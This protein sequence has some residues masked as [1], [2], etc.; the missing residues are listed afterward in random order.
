MCTASR[1]GAPTSGLQQQAAAQRLRNRELLWKA[2]SKIRKMG[3]N[4]EGVEKSVCVGGGGGGGGVIA[5]NGDFM[6]ALSQQCCKTKAGAPG[7]GDGD[8]QTTVKLH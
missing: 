1:W 3:Q 6:P 2:N 7:T 8:T 4:G 5:V